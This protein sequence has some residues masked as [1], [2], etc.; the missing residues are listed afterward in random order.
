VGFLG[1]S[2]LGGVLVA[3]A[4][5]ETAFL[6]M[7]AV[8]AGAAWPLARIPRDPVPDYRGHEDQA[9]QAFEELASGFRTVTR[10]P[11]A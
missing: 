1:G 6:V 7:A 10:D 4:S 5:F 3:A 9:E 2:L 11:Y 8:F